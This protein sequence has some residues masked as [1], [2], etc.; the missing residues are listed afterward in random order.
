MIYNFKKD[1]KVFI[2]SSGVLYKIDIYPDITFSQT[3]KETDYDRKTLHEPLSL[4]KGG[5]INQ[6][7]VVNFST[8]IPLR[9][10]DTHSMLYSLMS[11]DYFSG[12]IQSFDIYVQLNSV[13]YK[14]EQSVIENVV[15]NI[16]MRSI[17]TISISGTAAKISTV[18]NLPTGSIVYPAGDYLAIRGIEVTIDDTLLDSIASMHIEIA[19]TITWLP[20]NTVHSAVA[21][22][23]S[24]PYTYVLSGRRLSG[25]ITQFLTDLSINQGADYG[26]YPISIDIYTSSSSTILTFDLPETIF[27]RR[28]NVEDLITR[29]YDFRL[30]S[31]ELFK[32]PEV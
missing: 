1:A 21:S 7:N 10:T 4:Y 30:T 8:T 14:V 19:N 20:Y 26:T 25:S 12:N 3:F 23:T 6:A 22:T 9:S 27:T 11:P 15:Y 17:L 32:Y 2:Y 29:V 16:D 18:P 28:L 13:I 24:Y 31:N 5:T